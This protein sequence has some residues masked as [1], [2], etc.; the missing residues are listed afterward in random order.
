MTQTKTMKVQGKSSGKRIGTTAR[1]IVDLMRINPEISIPEI[2]KEVQTS[3]R[4]V[5]KHTSNLQK[6]GIIRR[7]DGD[8]GG[9]WEIIEK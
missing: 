2:A 1:K 5:E 7:V 4:N 3:E 9:H 8:K 6:K